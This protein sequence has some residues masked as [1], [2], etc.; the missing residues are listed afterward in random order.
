VAAN[1]AVHH[2]LEELASWCDSVTSGSAKGTRR[3]PS[4]E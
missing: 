2:L 4:G 3:L 1:Q